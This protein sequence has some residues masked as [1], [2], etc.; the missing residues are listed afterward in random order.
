[1]ASDLQMILQHEPR[2]QDAIV[3]LGDPDEEVHWAAQ[4]K[5]ICADGRKHKAFLALTYREAT[6][7]CLPYIP[8]VPWVSGAATCNLYRTTLSKFCFPAMVPVSTHLL[9]QIHHAASL[10]EIPWDI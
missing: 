1:M 9:A 3:A 8:H 5:Q 6:S 7:L 2:V 4:G 10:F